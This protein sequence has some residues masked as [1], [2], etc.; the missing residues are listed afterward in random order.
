MKETLT[1][2][3][4]GMSCSHCKTAIEKAVGALPGVSSAEVDLPKGEVAVSGDAPDREKI[5]AAIEELGY[6]VE[7]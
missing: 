5:I 2:K 7:K 4:G 1:L 3:V 6:L